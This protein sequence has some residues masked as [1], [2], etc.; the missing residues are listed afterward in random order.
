MNLRRRF[1]IGII[2]LFFAG[3]SAVFGIEILGYTAAEHDRF[4]NSASFIGASFDFS[5]VGRSSGNHWVTMISD[6]YFITAEH[7]R[8]TNNNVRFYYTNDPLGGFEERTVDSGY[9]LEIGPAGS[10]IWIGRLTSATSS[11]V[12][13]YDLF[14]PDP[15]TDAELLNIYTVGKAAG[16]GYDNLR[17][18][19]NQIDLSSVGVRNTTGGGGVM[20]SQAY[21]FTY[22]SIPA[23][24]SDESFF[25]SGDSGAPTFVEVGGELQ[26][27]GI[28][29]E[30]LDI[31]GG[32]ASNGDVSYDSFVGAYGDEIRAEAIPEPGTALLLGVGSMFV[33]FNRRQ[34]RAS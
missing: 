1:H 27:I 34:R 11:N 8:P 29:S 18:G 2:A 25:E 20:N 9:G 22:N 16:G 28:H 13:S 7:F 32:G 33:L 14:E 19:T 6:T 23:F 10:D 26:L 21:S 31:G 17:L 15:L 4:E 24:N 30:R 3:N 12:T 5:G